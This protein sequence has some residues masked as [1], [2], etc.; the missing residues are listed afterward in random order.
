MK[1]IR[2]SKGRGAFAVWYGGVSYSL[3]EIPADVEY[4][5]TLGAAEQ[6]FWER[7][8]LSKSKHQMR[9]VNRGP[10]EPVYTPAV[11]KKS[12]S[13]SLYFADPSDNRDPYPDQEIRFGPQGGIIRRRA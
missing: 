1:P 3:P 10:F 6:A 12:A 13:M 5:P 9:F 7:A 11:D 4:F 2:I 8:N